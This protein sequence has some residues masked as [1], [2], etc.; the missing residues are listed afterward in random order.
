[1]GIACRIPFIVAAVEKAIR[2]GV[3]RAVELVVNGQVIFIV[4]R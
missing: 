2:V 1:M 3:A 4:K